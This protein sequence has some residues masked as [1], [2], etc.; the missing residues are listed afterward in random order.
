MK[1]LLMGNHA[2]ANRGDAAISRGLVKRLRQLMPNAEYTFISRYPTSS[3]FLLGESYQHDL[4]FKFYQ[5]RR[6]GVSGRIT[7]F[8][9][10][11]YLSR[12]L[13]FVVNHP[14]IAKRALLPAEFNETIHQLKS[15]D[16]VIQVGGSNFVDM[17][18]NSQFDWALCT[19]LAQRPL[20]LIG[21]SVGP[22]QNKSFR[23]IAAT[24]FKACVSLQ[25]R[26]KQSLQLM[27][28]SGL[29]MSKVDVGS[30]TAWLV[31]FPAVIPAELQLST[32]HPT[33]AFTV[34]QLHPFHE[35]LGLPQQEYNSAIVQSVHELID[36]GYAIQFISTCTGIDGYKNDDRMLALEL[37]SLISR[38]DRVHVEMRELN[39]IEIG[40]IL[41]QCHF[42]VA[43]RL[44][45]AILAMAA[46]SVAVALSY[47]HKTPGIFQALGLSQLCVQLGPQ[48]LSQLQSTLK[49]VCQDLPELQKRCKLAT[50]LE[51]SNA[52][53]SISRALDH[54]QNQ[55]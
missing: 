37:A 51:Q 41:R 31:D 6:Q 28:Q 14:L 9:Y 43:T 22:F 53:Q 36:A 16:L 2:C 34:R 42:T 47:E 17:Y 50:S 52:N 19:L 39:D 54:W 44:H 26:E 38:P 35:R 7:Q 8:L 23:K 18:G 27:E 45:S 5:R 46:G 24:V 13:A 4:L 15:Y 40:L 12:F 29:P 25:L 32:V 20:L 55:Q 49:M 48:F 10:A 11:R 30:D 1:I 21:H 3:T 33:V